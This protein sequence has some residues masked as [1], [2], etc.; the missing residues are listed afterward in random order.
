MEARGKY[1]VAKKVGAVFKGKIKTFIKI[2]TNILF[3][4]LITI[5]IG[6]LFAARFKCINA[7]SIKLDF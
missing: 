3:R 7:A 5:K 2:N 4:K 1:Q 6:N